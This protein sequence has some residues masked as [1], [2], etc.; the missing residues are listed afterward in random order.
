MNKQLTNLS[1][2]IDTM[3]I[4]INTCVPGDVLDMLVVARIITQEQLDRLYKELSDHQEC[5]TQV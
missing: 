2:L 3:A 1:E 4:V 5:A